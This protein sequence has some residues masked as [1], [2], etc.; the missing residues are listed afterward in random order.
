M[1]RFS[2]TNGVGILWFRQEDYGRVLS[3]APDARELPGS[4]DQ[5]LQRAEEAISF[6]LREGGR[7]VRVDASVDKILAYLTI[8]GMRLDSD[9]RNTFAAD[10]ANW[11]KSS[12]H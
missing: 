4:Y 11:P 2:E 1:G 6:I 8:R 9:G 5:W 7:P 3:I 10:P 12:M